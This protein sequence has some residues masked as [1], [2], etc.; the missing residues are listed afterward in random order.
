MGKA[1]TESADYRAEARRLAD[2]VHGRLVE[3]GETVAVAESLTGGLVSA[4]LT[5]APGTS[6]TF[7]GGLVVYSV[8]AKRDLAGVDEHD[9]DKFGAVHP[10]IAEQ[11]AIGART[12]LGAD[13]GVGLTGVAG[14][15]TQDER[16]VGEVHIAVAAATF[17]DVRTHRFSGGREDIRLAAAAAALT[18]LIEAIA[19]SH[20]SDAR[21]E[22]AAASAG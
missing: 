7:R 15:A 20:E 13:Y 2:V 17:T 10:A 21:A 22:G 9:L 1:S 8:D 6:V 11:L 3:G 14:P 18:Q 16:P 12:R 4:L 5:E 19:R